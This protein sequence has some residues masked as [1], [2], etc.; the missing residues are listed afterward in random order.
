M[1]WRVGRRSLA[2]C[3]PEQQS[4]LTHLCK[5]NDDVGRLQGQQPCCWP[6][7]GPSVPSFPPLLAVFQTLGTFRQVR[8]AAVYVYDSLCTHKAWDS[9]PELRYRSS[10]AEGLKNAQQCVQSKRNK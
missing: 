7:A 10:Y 3:A 1:T 5:V 4:W 8:N 6:T 9:A 2:G